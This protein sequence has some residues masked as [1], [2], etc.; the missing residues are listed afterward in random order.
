MICVLKE[1][2]LYLPTAHQ[3]VLEFKSSRINV[4]NEPSSGVL[5]TSRTPEII[6]ETNIIVSEIQV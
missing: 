4:D 6:E 2:V 1:S 3:W 5:K